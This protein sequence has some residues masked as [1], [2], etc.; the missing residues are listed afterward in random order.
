MARLHAARLHTLVRDKLVIEGEGTVADPRDM[1]VDLQGIPVPDRL[2]KIR[3]AMHQRQQTSLPDQS[4]QAEPEFF[5]ETLIGV[6]RQPKVAGE[7]HHP[8]CIDIVQLGLIGVSE[9][10]MAH[11]FLT[12]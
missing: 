7:E 3:R 10:L 6:V 5:H 2:E 11:A 12:P 4:R 1:D 8:G 9:G